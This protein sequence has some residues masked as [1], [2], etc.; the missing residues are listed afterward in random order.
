MRLAFQVVV[1]FLHLS[2]GLALPSRHGNVKRTETTQPFGTSFGVPRNNSFDYVI[3]GG[4]NADLT[5]AARLAKKH[6]VAVIEAGSFYEIGNGNRSNIPAYDIEYTGKDP[7]DTNPLIYWGFSTTPQTELLNVSAHYTRGKTLGG[8]SAR[9]YMAYHRGTRLAYQK[10]ADDIDDQS[11]SFKDM[12][13]F[14]EKSI[15]YTPPDGQ[16]RAQNATPEVDLSNLTSNNSDSPL[17]VTFANYAQPASS[18]VQRAFQQISVHPITGFTSGNLIGSSYTLAT[19]NAST[20][21]RDSSETSFLRSSLN[22]GN[23]TIYTSSLATKIIFDEHKVAVGVNVDTEGLNYTLSDVPKDRFNYATVSIAVVAPQSSGTISITSKDMKD[24][25]LVN[26]RWLTD[27]ADREVL[28]A[29]IKRVRELF[30]TSSMQPVLIGTEAFP[31]PDE[32]R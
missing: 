4:G 23:L 22:N 14:F 17:S 7:R 3:V 19:I 8:C 13:P 28:L 1:L 6:T 10:W 21:T 11:Y 30:A 27:L 24:P 20:Q 5:L 12:L 26:P 9:N 31:G 25:R 16:K 2:G 18:W 15:H 32:D 29:G